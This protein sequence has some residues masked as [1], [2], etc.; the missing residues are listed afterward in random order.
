MGTTNLNSFTYFKFNIILCAFA[1]YLFII[2]VAQRLRVTVTFVVSI[3]F[4]STKCVFGSV[5]AF[6]VVSIVSCAWL[7]ETFIR[8]NCLAASWCACAQQ[9]SALLRFRVRTFFFL[10]NSTILEPYF[11]LK[12]HHNLITSCTLKFITTTSKNCIFNSS[13]SL[14]VE[15]VSLI[16]SLTCFSERFK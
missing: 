16:H 7:F 14:T 12:L 6:I 3:I 1:V 9:T 15:A 8:L 4:D 13:P 5:T 11:N 2:R 10:L